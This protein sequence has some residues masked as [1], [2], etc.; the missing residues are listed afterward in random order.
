MSRDAY[1][2]PALRRAGLQF[3]SGKLVSAGL[4]LVILIWLVR[5]LP[6]AEY[7]VYVVL[8]ATAEIGFAVAGLG[9]P[10]LAAR[11]VPDYRMNGDGASLRRLFEHLIFCQVLVLAILVGLVALALDAYLAW[12][13]LLQH[14]AAAWL[15]LILLIGEGLARFEREA[16]LSPLMLQGEARTSML[17]RQGAFLVGL[18]IFDWLGL[19]TVVSVVAIESFASLLGL[20]A[21]HYLLRRHLA[22]ARQQAAKPGW[23]EP[24]LL[25]QWKLALRMYVAH[26]VT[27]ACGPQVFL[28]IVQRSLGT[29]AAAVFGFLRTLYVQISG[30][31]PATL[32][33]TVI[34]PKL[35]ATFLTEGMIGLAQQANLVGK[36]SLFVLM[37]LILIVALGGNVIVG[38]LSGGKF[39]T[40]GY[41]FLG[42]LLVLVPFSQRQLMETVAVAA[43]RAGLCTVASISAFIALPI[44]LWLI[45]SGLGLWAPILAMFAGQAVFNAVVVI[46]LLGT[47]Y[48]P[49]LLGL[50]K[51]A[52]TTVFS[53]FVVSQVLLED[54]GPGIWWAG[55]AFTLGLI[56]Y[57]MAAWFI[58]PFGEA[59]RRSI[60]AIAGRRFFVW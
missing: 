41:L 54:R 57:A 32:L 31:L 17:V 23:R 49:D 4:T 60:N 9:M 58:K 46:G 56:V 1:S 40:S 25:M 3:L 37:P 10:W 47:G 11:F 45:E 36:L 50:S 53:W 30:Y 29:D 15:A 34:R 22:S 33:F 12:A 44:M 35:M 26:L 19:V 21:A 42:L 28:N 14:R 6:V 18:A 43:N 2:L 8:I 55:V 39:T 16:L 38:V 7:G 27:L 5:A 20:V 13:G 24:S 59:E 52:L 51:L 48:R